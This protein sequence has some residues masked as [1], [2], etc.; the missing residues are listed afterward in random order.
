MG[1]K[2]N[3]LPDLHQK[4]TLRDVSLMVGAIRV[5]MFRGK[6]TEREAQILKERFLERLGPLVA[7]QSQVDSC[8]QQG[9]SP[10]R[11][12]EFVSSSRRPVCALNGSQEKPGASAR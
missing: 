4:P 8:V 7:S 5:V 2:D 3:F 11:H 12:E 10:T 1:R 9:K 6:I